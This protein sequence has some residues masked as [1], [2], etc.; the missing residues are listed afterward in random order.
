MAFLNNSG[1]IILDVCLTDN[2]RKV[3]SIGDGSF[4]ITKFALGDDE[5]DYS[6]YNSSHASG[7]SYYDLE[8]LQ[9]PILEA[10]TDNA[11]SMKSKLVT[12]ES[13]DLLFLPVLLLNET[14]DTLSARSP[15]TNSFIVA[16]DGYTENDNGAPSNSTTN[17]IG[18]TADGAPRPGVIFG[19][20]LSVGA[21][22][23]I[24]QG[25]NTSQISYKNSRAMSDMIET[26]Y[27]IQI[28]SRLGK[29][30][31]KLGNVLTPDYV[32]DDGIAY[33][34]I[35]STMDAVADPLYKNI[36]GLID[37]Q[38][39]SP[40]Q[41]P[42]GSRIEF[43]IASSLDLQTSTYLFTT[44]GSESTL[45]NR[46]D[47]AGTTNVYHIDSIVRVTGMVHGGSVDIP[48]RFVKFKS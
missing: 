16:V 32:D 39:L 36:N 17:G 18:Q 13:L 27:V 31:S 44:L 11:A 19:E 9:T 30:S 8:I 46:A 34:T 25:L 43:K 40:I 29:I 7:S 47:P 10:F 26:E 1:D 45:A 35:L 2:G 12:Y 41:G 3:L 22:I 48:V 37:S 20:T 5:I 14:T 23:I 42:R 24:D 33:Y 6:L 4:K 21:S 15:Q 38:S 28:D